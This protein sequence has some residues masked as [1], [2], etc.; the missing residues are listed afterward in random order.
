M[1]H[2]E[3][4]SPGVGPLFGGCWKVAQSQRCL[5]WAWKN[6]DEGGGEGKVPDGENGMWKAPRHREHDV[7]LRNRRDTRVTSVS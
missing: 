7:R 6:E 4:V 3:S 2:L 5:G 1:E